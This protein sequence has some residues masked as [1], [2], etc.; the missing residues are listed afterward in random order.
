MPAIDGRREVL[1][2]LPRGSVQHTGLFLDKMLAWPEPRPGQGPDEVAKEALRALLDATTGIQVPAGY[3]RAYGRRKLLLEGLAGSVEGGVTKMWRATARGRLV[4]GLGAAA[5]RETNIALLH[6]WGVPYIP[7]SALKGLASAAAHRSKVETWRKQHAQ[8]PQGEDHHLLFGDTAESGC[9]VFHDAWWIPEGDKLPVDL[10]TMTVHHPDYY[11]GSEPP[12]DWDEP[13]PVAFLTARGAFLIALTGP[14]EWVDAAGAWL[15]TALEQDGIGAKTAAGYGRMELKHVPTRLEEARRKLLAIVDSFRDASNANHIFSHIE[16]AVEDAAL[17]AG[18]RQAMR[19]LYERAPEFWRA[20]LKNKASAGQQELA[21]RFDMVPPEA[22][23]KP[24]PRPVV[25]EA[26][27]VTEV[28]ERGRAWIATDRKNRPTLY[29]LSEAQ[30]RPEERNTKDM[31]LGDGNLADELRAA[32]A[33]A[34]IEVEVRRKGRKLEHV[35]R[36]AGGR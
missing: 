11:Q 35:R 15:A 1:K 20:W 36:P 5:V 30:A 3:S 24:E 25:L 13:N 9:V 28:W 22:P 12:A 19:A 32:S 29:F 27:S 10:D 17:H 21:K 26:T 23:P 33:Q 14:E 7:G 16:K 34:P 4:V 6:T 8:M 31:D 18:V 2:E